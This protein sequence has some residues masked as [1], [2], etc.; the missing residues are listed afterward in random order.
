M[1]VRLSR[2]C[3]F[4]DSLTEFMGLLL[5]VFTIE[6]LVSYGICC[7]CGNFS[8][9]TSSEQVNKYFVMDDG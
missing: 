8:D 6:Y 9:D 7:H 4:A 2:K 3:M 5:V 1:S